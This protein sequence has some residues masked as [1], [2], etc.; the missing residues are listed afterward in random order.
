MVNNIICGIFRKTFNHFLE[1][2][3]YKW[4]DNYFAKY[5]NGILVRIFTYYKYCESAKK[6]N[7]IVQARPDFCDLTDD[8]EAKAGFSLNKLIFRN[9]YKNSIADF[10]EENTE[11]MMKRYFEAF[12]ENYDRYFNFSSLLDYAE[13]FTDFYKIFNRGMPYIVGRDDH[14]L[15]ELARIDFPELSYIW[16]RASEIEI[17]KAHV[18]DFVCGFKEFL[19]NSIQYENMELPGY[20]LSERGRN[21]IDNSYKIYNTLTE[22]AEALYEENQMYFEN[23]NIRYR[24]NDSKNR[25]YISSLGL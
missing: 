3:G 6:L 22:F 15:L 8:F 21:L 24:R 18:M 25:T 1:E 4:H 17:C 23:L 10:S 20:K 14:R 9:P 12:S 19:Y 11:R 13:K 5:E 7:V 16:Y 2:K